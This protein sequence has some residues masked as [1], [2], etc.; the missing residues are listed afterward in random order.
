M[1]DTTATYR[2]AVNTIRRFYGTPCYEAA[3][4]LL[5]SMQ[6][7]KNDEMVNGTDTE[8]MVR[9]QG[10]VLAIKRIVSDLKATV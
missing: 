1:S 8:E 6:S 7:L 5:N 2:N 3:I 9:A 10:G 4:D